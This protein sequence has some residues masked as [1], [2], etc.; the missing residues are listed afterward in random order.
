MCATTF[1]LSEFLPLSP[2]L[3][4]ECGRVGGDIDSIAM[5]ITGLKYRISNRGVGTRVSTTPAM[6]MS[7]HD[8]AVGN[9]EWRRKEGRGVD[10][11]VLVL[12]IVGQGQGQ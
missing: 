4:A 2:V 3:L 5:T 9:I 6:K 1:F 10:E 8:M 12:V 7:W 11:T